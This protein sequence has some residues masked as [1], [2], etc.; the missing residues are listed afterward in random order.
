[1][2]SLIPKILFLWWV[3][4]AMGNTRIR[5]C[6][7]PSHPDAAPGIYTNYIKKLYQSKFG[8]SNVILP[9]DCSDLQNNAFQDETLLYFRTSKAECKE[10]ENNIKNFETGVGLSVDWPD[11]YLLQTLDNRGDLETEEYEPYTKQILSVKMDTTQAQ[12]NF[13]SKT[14]QTTV[15]TTVMLERPSSYATNLT[16]CFYNYRKATLDQKPED[17]EWCIHPFYHVGDDLFGTPITFSSTGFESGERGLAGYIQFD[18]RLFSGRNKKIV[19]VKGTDGRVL[20]GV[21]LSGCAPPEFHLQI[22]WKTDPQKECNRPVITI[23]DIKEIENFNCRM[24]FTTNNLRASVSISLTMQESRNRIVATLSRY[25]Y[26]VSTMDS[27]KVILFSNMQSQSI[28]QC[29]FSE[30]SR[31]SSKW[32]GWSHSSPGRC[33]VCSS[34]ALQSRG[35]AV[36]RIP[37]A[38]NLSIESERSMDCCFDCARGFNLLTYQLRHETLQHCVKACSDGFAYDDERAQG[39]LCVACPTGKYTRAKSGG[40]GGCWTCSALGF[41]NAIVNTKRGGCVSCGNRHQASTLHGRPFCKP[42]NAMEYVPESDTECRKCPD[43]E[44]LIS[45]ESTV[46]TPCA[47]GFVMNSMRNCILCPLQMFKSTAGKG[48][49]T[50]CPLGTRSLPNRTACVPCEGL[51]QT[52]ARY[53]MYSPKGGCEVICNKMVSY[54]HTSNPY[55]QDG[56]RPCL[57]PPMGMYPVMGDCS[58]FLACNN[59]PSSSSVA[60]YTG[61]GRMGDPGSCPWTCMKGFTLSANRRECVACQASGFNPT[62]HVYTMGCQFACLPGLYYRGL[63]NRDTTCAQKCTNLLTTSGAVYPLLTD[64]YRIF[65]HNASVVER[66][67]R[68]NF[69]MGH[70]GSDAKAPNSEVALLRNIGIYGYASVGMTNMCGNSILNEREEC[71][72]GNKKDG[73][74]CSATCMIERNGFWDCG[75]IGERCKERCGWNEQP[76]REQPV[77][78]IGFQF[79][80][81]EAIQKK[82]PWCTGVSYHADFLPVPTASK[83]QWMLEKLVSCHCKQQPMQTLPYSECNYTNHGCRECHDGEYKDDL[84]SRCARC[85]S[86]CSIGFR[87]FNASVDLA[88]TDANAEI[89]SRFQFDSLDQCGPAISTSVDLTYADPVDDPFHFGRDQVMIGCVPCTMIFPN[90]LSRIVFVHGTSGTCNWM[91]KRDPA[92]QT[93]V[94]YFCSTSNGTVCNGP[95]LSCDD[96]LIRVKNEAN[97]LVGHYILPCMDMV[98]HTL[99]RCSSLNANADAHYTGNSVTIVGDE[100]GCPWACNTGFQRFEDTC[101]RCMAPQN[102]LCANG[103]KALSCSGMPNMFYCAPCASVMQGIEELKVME[104]WRSEGPLFTRCFAGCEP[105]LAF[106]T[107]VSDTTELCQPCTQQSCA[108]GAEFVPCTPTTDSNCEPCRE[109]LDANEEFYIG[110]SCTRRCTAGHTRNSNQLCSPCSERQCG[111]GMRREHSC[112]DPTQREQGLPQCIPCALNEPLNMPTEGRIWEP[113]VEEECLTSCKEGWMF[114]DAGT[115]NLTCVACRFG[116]CPAGFEAKCAGG[117]KM[118]LPCSQISSLSNMRYAGPGNCSR[119]CVSAEFA[120]PFPGA[121]YCIAVAP[122]HKDPDQPP[123]NPTMPVEHGVDLMALALKARNGTS[124]GA[125]FPLRSVPH[126]AFTPLS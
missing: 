64:Y 61:G 126:S 98:G 18:K 70:C 116:E 27:T 115:R 82:L 91:C 74:G 109:E 77:G 31:V 10:I 38:C 120:L 93:D 119:V 46:C 52:L 108:I 25:N 89:K 110:G 33:T 113:G 102:L 2:V 105:G 45:A 5:I 9:K 106:K 47:P 63:D 71:E 103:E 26:A 78:L 123:S 59:A 101:R 85:G 125:G 23:T 111:L 107:N 14:S 80:P 73:D 96:S 20:S 117:A 12:H 95:C 1:M 24:P 21:S 42:C 48:D 30:N 81:Q 7:S 88:A 92:N 44:R 112:M 60:E 32:D 28:A 8:T 84:Y 56:C 65:L 11:H 72:D 37:R 39:P 55:A 41:R 17:Y 36:S 4:R 76:T 51:N 34:S 75:L 53:A 94:D 124:E 35:S 54:A 40:R 97:R 16:K 121:T 83:T 122:G 62:L 29:I 86:A 13:L 6:D 58:S 104:V 43:G 19:Q 79:N 114:D 15:W 22:V 90:T 66:R 68:P 49:C 57:P 87:P 50:V 69:I 99:G 3:N 118:C 100:S 67:G